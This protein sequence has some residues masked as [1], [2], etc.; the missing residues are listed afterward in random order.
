MAWRT[1]GRLGCGGGPQ[2]LFFRPALGDPAELQEGIGHHRHQCVAMEPGPGL[3]LE[4]VEAEFF[5]KL[6][7]G[8]LANQPSFLSRHVLGSSGADP[9]G[10]SVGDAHAHNS[11]ACAQASLRSLA[12]TDLTPLHVFKHGVCSARLGVW[13]VLNP[14]SPASLHREDQVHIGQ[15]DL[16]VPRDADGP[17]KA[18]L[19]L[20]RTGGAMYDAASGKLLGVQNYL[21]LLTPAGPSRLHYFVNTARSFG[22]DRP[23]LGEMQV[24][25]GSRIQPEDIEAIEAIEQVLQSGA[26]MPR[27]ISARVDTGALKVRRRLEMQI[28][29]ESQRVARHG[30]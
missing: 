1:A 21:H 26:T 9:L 10:S 11:K 23:E 30:K 24:A 5:L 18:A 27:E 6:L 3:A 29:L 2:T 25:M 22:I 19:A 16:L 20:I 12:P 14:R 17:A 15:A 7:M 4:V 28:R 8:L 13:H